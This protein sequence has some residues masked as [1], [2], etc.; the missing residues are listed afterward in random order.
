[1]VAH[2]V[3]MPD[4]LELVDEVHTISSLTGFEALL[5]GKSVSCYGLP[6]YAG[7]GLTHDI[8]ADNAPKR[9]YIQRRHRSSPLTLEQLI[10]CTLI[11]YPMYRLPDGYGLAQVEQVIDYLYEQEASKTTQKKSAIVYAKTKLMQARNIVNR[12]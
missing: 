5:R 12:T 8:D 6:F 9:D 7:W 4:C 2:D 3:A 10:Y 11:E 1:M